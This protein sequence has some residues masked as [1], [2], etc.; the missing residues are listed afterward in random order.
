MVNDLGLL[1]IQTI[2]FRNVYNTNNNKANTLKPYPQQDGL[3]TLCIKTAL[4]QYSGIIYVLKEYKVLDYITNDQK[5]IAN[6]L[7]KN[8]NKS[9]ISSFIF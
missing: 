6:I 3:R 2:K 8:M 7:L 4:Y 5:Y 9:N 1:Y